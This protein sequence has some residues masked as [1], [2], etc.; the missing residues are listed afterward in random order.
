M[1]ANLVCR[2]LPPERSA[3]IL[4]RFRG[5]GDR[6]TRLPN[7]RFVGP[8]RRVLDELVWNSDIDSGSRMG[9][10][11][12]T[13]ATSVIRSLSCQ[14]WVRRRVHHR[15]RNF[16]PGRLGNPYLRPR[17]WCLPGIL[18]PRTAGT[19]IVCVKHGDVVSM[20]SNLR[21]LSQTS[22]SNNPE[23]RAG[24]KKRRQ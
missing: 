21:I 22:A 19:T 18:A 11:A 15:L 10:P 13:L 2:E 23:L 14:A 7:C 9:R 16:G 6:S 1:F 17:W 12:C 20:K 8:T 5:A 24:K 4:E 3:V